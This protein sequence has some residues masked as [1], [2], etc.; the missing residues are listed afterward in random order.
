MSRKTNTTHLIGGPF[1]SRYASAGFSLIEVLVVLALMGL[2]ASVIVFAVNDFDEPQRYVETMEIM[3]DIKE[4]LLGKPER[5]CNGWKQFSG[6]VAD[7]GV[8]PALLDNADREV[9]IGGQPKALWTRDLN[10]DGD[11]QD[12]GIDI[13]DDFLWKYYPDA[14]IWAGWRGPYVESPRGAVLKDGWGNALMFIRGEVATVKEVYGGGA[15]RSGVFRCIKNFAGLAHGSLPGFACGRNVWDECWEPFPEGMPGPVTDPPES[16]KTTDSSDSEQTFLYNVFYGRDDAL[17][18]ASFG[19]DGKPGGLGLDKDIIL[20]I[21]RTDWTGEVAGHAGYRRNQYVEALSIQ[22]PQYGK[23][24]FIQKKTIRVSDNDGG[25]GIHFRFGTAPE[26]G[27]PC[28]QGCD[29]D[30]YDN[31]L[32]VSVPMGIR[33]IE[34]EGRMH[35]FTVEPTGNWV[36]TIR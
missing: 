22:Y 21:Y 33:S 20:T 12:P 4:A 34:A 29:Y 23:T 6:Y 17:T 31:F 8:L 3:A 1:F 19:A 36:G 16:Y 14:K 2:L 27:D 28:R 26:V 35:V 15:W 13:V 5:Y 7:M 11:T 18:I 32:K 24:D 30:G 10:N 9:D 25:Y